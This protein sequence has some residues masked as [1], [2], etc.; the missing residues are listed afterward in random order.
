L[1]QICIVRLSAQIGP[2]SLNAVDLRGAK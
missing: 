2:A 1:Y